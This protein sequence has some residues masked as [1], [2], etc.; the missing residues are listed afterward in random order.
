[1]VCRQ[2]TAATAPSAACTR[3]DRGHSCPSASTYDARFVQRTGKNVFNGNELLVKGALEAGVGL[4]VGYPGSPVA[5]VFDV[6]GQLREL[7]AESGIVAQ[8]ANN[9]ALAAARLNG[10]QMA[11]VRA[12]AFMKSVGGHVAADGLAITNLAGVHPQGGA[13]LV[14]GDDP[15]TDSTQ[16][17]ADSRYLLQ[18]LRI[19]VV[20]PATFQELKDWLD[21]SFELSTAANLVIGYV[22]TTNQADGAGVVRVRPNRRPSLN[23]RERTSLD[24]RSISSDDRVMLAPDT[25]RME[26]DVVA[27]RFPRLLEQARQIGLDRVLHSHPP[28]SGGNSTCRER[29]GVI[30]AGMAYSYVEHA[31]DELDIQKKVPI[32]KLGLVYP[33]D[34]QQIVNFAQQ[35]D[36][37]VVI[38]EQRDFIES[39][40]VRILRD[41]RQSGELLRE[42]P[43]W[44][45]QFPY[46]L[47]GI[48]SVR[49]LNPSLIIRH[50]GPLLEKV[51][52]STF[53]L[54]IVQL[55][56]EL[57]RIAQL[58]G[59]PVRLPVRTPTFCPGC[60]HRDS[61]S[62]LRDLAR[63][64]ENEDYMRSQH[65]CCGQDI[66]FHGDIGC[67]VMLKYDPYK[68]LMHNLSGMGL[69]GGTGAGIDPFI[70][71]KQVVFMGDSTFFHSGMSAISDSIKNGQNIT[72]VILDNK[73]T[74]MTGHQP[75]PAQEVDLMGRPTVAQD[76]E[77][78]VRAMGQGIAGSQV[79]QVVRMNPGEQ[80]RYRRALEEIIL[81]PGVKVVVADKECAITAGR[82][83]RADRRRTIA[84][85]GFLRRERHMNITPE[86][87]EH[88]LE[89]TKSTG[90]TGLTFVETDYGR[91]VATDL[92][93]CV[94]D[95]ACSKRLV[96]PSFERVEIFRTSPPPPHWPWSVTAGDG[97]PQF[98][99]LPDAPVATFTKSYNIF[100]AG[101]G[102]M[103]VGTLTAT[104][105]N[106]AHQAGF[107]C[108]LCDKK[109]LAIRNGG[110]YSRMVISSDGANRSP[111]IPYGKADLLLGLDLV[112][113]ARGVDPLANLCVAHSSRT[114]TIVN[115]AETYP[116]N[117]LIGKEDFDAESL[118]QTLRQHT[119]GG[120]FW[121]C[122][123]SRVAESVLGHK[124]Y[125]NMILLGV[126][127]QK[128]GLP[129]T[130]THLLSAMRCTVSDSEWDENHRAFQLGRLLA[131]GGAE[132]E[133]LRR[134]LQPVEVNSRDLTTLIEDKAAILRQTSSWKGC[135]VAQEYEREIWAAIKIMS[136][137][138]VADWRDMALR[139]YDL[140]LYQDIAYAR[141]TY[142]NRVIETYRR[143][144]ATY[145]Y[146]ATR[147]VIRYLYKVV[148]IKD[149]IWVSHLL[150]SEEKRRRDYARFRIDPARGDRI[151]I[152][153]LNRP[154][155][156]LFGFK[157][158][159]R[160]RSRPWMLA[161]MKRMKFLRRLSSWHK[162]EAQFRDRYIALVDRLPFHT[163]D[164]Y[165]TLVR[166]LDS[167]EN[168][169]GYVE[170]RHPT[171]VEPLSRIEALIRGSADRAGTIHPSDYHGVPDPH[172]S[173][174]RSAVTPTIP[175]RASRAS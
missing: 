127:F 80:Q 14:I 123:L 15:W 4:L 74:A 11:A 117:T 72:Y 166:A 32:L 151:R 3:S 132:S 67:Y 49:G 162:P 128:G 69:G 139:F 62:V 16:V 88:C 36:E 19:P 75:T 60:P 58:T 170:I 21:C 34:P 66:V 83:L 97:R 171:M 158:Q 125:A 106:A 39:Q 157:I 93:F 38:E 126:A 159:F 18:H 70:D 61:A 59:T 150:T 89:C 113:A 116:V 144:S 152:V 56:G 29:L 51:R 43:V 95:E 136:A 160:V 84:T 86:V 50:M 40:V 22:V 55:Q 99:D 111:L 5:D 96:C 148:A 30:T 1:L 102:G 131:L 47:R 23:H 9:E 108:Q 129:M 112:E 107:D 173:T 142:L 37:F 20:E 48:P 24:A 73:T 33:V 28:G 64:F 145:G 143:D 79:V 46:N 98:P 65:A 27:S 140:I 137:L 78:I 130:L 138:D 81:K 77:Q 54:D 76:I 87:C 35:V 164:E 167:P 165:D 146:R 120:A 103:G 52:Q 45:K 114:A 82:R 174:P 6:A 31:F 124:L 2:A 100:V 175:E 115:Q 57:S 121:A 10:S 26:A 154:E 94:N 172:F 25:A 53:G 13:V 155:F 63:D 169:R 110:V 90:C 141:Q 149:E 133:P 119:R 101:V 41:A 8:V 92:S 122:D 44:G 105:A 71:N 91:K 163:R 68:R 109:G 118:I 161:L 7:F 135:S 156:H 168:V 153:H 42:V 104:L 85:L 134:I 17:P 12:I 147:S